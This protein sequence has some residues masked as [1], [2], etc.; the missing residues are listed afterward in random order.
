MQVTTVEAL[1]WTR[2]AGS[3]C[4]AE[5]DR[6]G[7]PLAVRIVLYARPRRGRLT[8]DHVGDTGFLFG[9]KADPGIGSE[10]L[11]NLGVRNV[12]RTTS[13]WPSASAKRLRAAP[14]FLWVAEATER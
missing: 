13:P 12:A 6:S 9:G 8:L 14:L 11:G 4:T 7:E 3:Q 2:E 5:G 10:R 1:V